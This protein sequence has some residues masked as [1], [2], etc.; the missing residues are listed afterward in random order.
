[1]EITWLSSTWIRLARHWRRLNWDWWPP[2]IQLY[3]QISVSPNLIF[4]ASFFKKCQSCASTRIFIWPPSEV[5]VRR[6]GTQGRS[7][8]VF[9]FQSNFWDCAILLNRTSCTE[10]ILTTMAPAQPGCE[11]GNK[12]RVLI[13]VAVSQNHSIIHSSLVR[14]KWL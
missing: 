12:D 3:H 2:T 6:K 7:G 4:P 8:G 9:R 10:N 11:G 14:I 1:M 5:R 13:Y